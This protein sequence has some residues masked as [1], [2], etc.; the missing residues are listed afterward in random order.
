MSKRSIYDIFNDIDFDD[1]DINEE[2]LDE[3]ERQRIKN[4]MS[5]RITIKEEKKDKKHIRPM[6][7]VAAVI[8]II[9][10]ITV[11]SPIGREVMAEIKDKLFFSTSNG[12]IKSEA[13]SLYVLEEPLFIDLAGEKFKVSNVVNDGKYITLE[14]WRNHEEGILVDEYIK[15]LRDNLYVLTADGDKLT[16]EGY[17]AASGGY[18]SF[19][20]ETEE[21]GITDFKLCYEGGESVD[22]H[23]NKI[24][25]VDNYDKIG[26]NAKDQNIT[27]GV[28]EYY[29]NGERFFKVWSNL[30]VEDFKD[31]MVTFYGPGENLKVTDDEGDEVKLE[32]V[33]DGTGKAYKV[34][35]NPSGQLHVNI[36]SIE[37]QY[38]MSKPS[39]I[40]MKPPEDGETIEMEKEIDFKET[41][42][43]VYI[44]SVEN[45]DEEYIFSMDYSKNQ[46]EAR[47]II[48]SG[49]SFRSSGAMGDPENKCGELYI[50][51]EDLSLKEK[52]L[53][54]I[55]LSIGRIEMEIDG[56]WVIDIQ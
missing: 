48:M 17:M 9:L 35:G 2:P 32:R 38:R 31:Y 14:M 56:H 42:D 8:F 51:K 54:K 22:I 15:G 47:R 43:R 34:L 7:K 1:I 16:S 37:V 24:D 4:M 10:S 6:Y 53:N 33:E 12:I 21:S 25:Y 40:Q 52:L 19:S 41:G 45:R 49:E 30:D 18:F 11:L 26:P 20:F 29:E 13:A 55:D 27:I 44:T 23:L 3:I 46:D 39:K 28:T 36:E 50:D 5:E